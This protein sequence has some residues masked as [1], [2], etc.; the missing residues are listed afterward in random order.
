MV[1]WYLRAVSLQ[2]LGWRRS[3]ALRIGEVIAD[4]GGLWEKVVV[5]AVS[6]FRLEDTEAALACAV[7]SRQLPPGLLSDRPR[8]SIHLRKSIAS[9]CFQ[10]MKVFG[11][12]MEALALPL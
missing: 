6:R 7:S 1:E 4:A 9:D 8:T 3:S 12:R 11:A 5:F 10:L 2:V